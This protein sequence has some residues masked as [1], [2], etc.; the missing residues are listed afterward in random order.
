MGSTYLPD[1]GH[2][3]PLLVSSLPPS[4]SPFV[5]KEKK[6][7]AF[8]LSSPI[9]CVLSSLSCFSPLY[10]LSFAVKRKGLT[11]VRGRHQFFLDD[12]G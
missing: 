8:Y 11:E 1:R 12:G 7:G 6:T 10:Q 3:V 9:F 4:S 5:E 2:S